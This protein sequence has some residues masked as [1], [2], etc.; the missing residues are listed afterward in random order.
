MQ[1]PN[2][3]QVDH[4]RGLPLQHA[5]HLTSSSL[6]WLVVF[7]LDTNTMLVRFKST[8]TPAQPP[9]RQTPPSVSKLKCF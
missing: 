3:S 1:V 5:S 4:H 6:H 2:V 7:L 9:P 8:T